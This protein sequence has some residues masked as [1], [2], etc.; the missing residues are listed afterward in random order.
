MV[1]AV[2]QQAE[3]SESSQHYS[4]GQHVERDASAAVVGTVATGL[5]I[6]AG[7][8]CEGA[9]IAIATPLCFGLGL[10]VSVS[11]GIVGQYAVNKLGGIL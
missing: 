11:T 2:W 5:G 9:T 6:A 8:A 3:D 1:S 10:G 4:I 7:G